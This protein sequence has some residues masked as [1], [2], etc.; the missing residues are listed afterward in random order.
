MTA[1]ITA[2]AGQ[3]GTGLG[4]RAAAAVRL[5]AATAAGGLPAGRDGEE[6]IRRVVVG[7][8]VPARGGRLPPQRPG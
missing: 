2:L 4:E 5:L 6:A 7:E 8:Q 3:R 1:E